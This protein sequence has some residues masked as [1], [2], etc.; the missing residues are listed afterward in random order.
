MNRL[1]VYDVNK[2]TI[3]LKNVLKTLMMIT[4]VVLGLS[5]LSCS[6]KKGV[7]KE[8]AARHV[9]SASTYFGQ[10]Q[11]HAAMLEARNAVQ[12]DPDNPAGF[13][14]LGRIYNVLG[15]FDAAQK[16]LEPIQ[17][18]M[19]DVTPDLAESYLNNGKYRSVINILS[20]YAP[21]A[22]QPEQ[23]I[24]R[25]TYLAQSYIRLGDK[26]GYEQS[27]VDLKNLPNADNDVLTIE[28]E[29]LISQGQ[30]EAAAAKL[31][32]LAKNNNLNAK[33]YLM[34]GNFALQNNERTKAEDFFT[35]ALGLLPN[36]DVMTLERRIV[37]TQLTEALILQGRTS[38]AYRYQKILADANPEGK[39]AQ[40]KYSDAMELYRQ[41]KFADAEKLLEELRD[42][43]PQ[44]KNSAMLLGLVQ[45]QRG[46]DEQAVELFDKYID[47]ETASSSL[48]QAAALAKFRVKKTDEAI[49]MLKKAVEAQ[50]NSA[51]ILATYGLALLD[52]DPVSDEGQKALEKSLA[53]SPE[54]HRLRLALAKRHYAMK[55]NEQGLA[56]LRTAYRAAP[57]DFVVQETYFKALMQ[58]G[59]NDEL[60]SEIANFQKENPGSGRG[61]FIEGWYKLVI[62]D[63]TGAQVAFEK[64]LA[65]KDNNE[66]VMAFTGLAELYQ[67]QNQPQKAIN[68]WQTLLKEDPTQIPVYA[69][70]YA[71][72]RE[73]KRGPEAI[74][75]LTELE[76]KTDKWQPSAVLAQLLQDQQR[77]S[78][79]VKYIEH[80]LERSG[81]AEN[82]KQLAANLY[83]A[84]GVQLQAQ[85]KLDDAK[86]SL[87]KSLNF[88]PENAQYLASL[89]Q[90]E[91]NQKNIPE[92]QKLLDQFV[93]T[94]ENEYIRLYLQ[95]VIRFA[96]EKKEE[97]LD[98]Y[99]KSWA[100]QPS[101]LVGE[102]LLNYYDKNQQKAEAAT[103]LSDWSK[104]LPKS[105]RAALLQAVN[106]Q[107]EKKADEAIKWYEKAIEIAPNSPI[108]LNNLAWMYYERKNPAAIE[109]A[110]KAAQLAPNSA[111]ILD[112]YGWIL[113]EN[114]Q[115][116]EGVEVLERANSLAK[117]NKEI[118]D[119][120]KAAKAK[121]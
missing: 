45:F 51:D 118:S 39:A 43:F 10:G 89:I 82:V 62:K 23:A 113:V 29:Y 96:E 85:G 49:A 114:G 61:A 79:A 64:A 55:N 76:S 74:T 65:V 54:K 109:L 93:H 9:T 50:P 36:T 57:I 20:S 35:K 37:L 102:A 101:E 4:V 110:K 71:I 90:F 83:H 17:K 100:S 3:E 108:A 2:K 27:L 44:D 21:E 48:I 92:A 69:K 120:L 81:K 99:R 94:D 91:I 1:H 8:G 60:K 16:T 28:S 75:F 86:V 12:K 11:F 106:A 14:M 24:R 70:W 7:D 46:Q 97:G 121:K 78:E 53:I 66:R 119:H 15:S 77:T 5:T 117:D 18:K 59:K 13:V 84:N 42:Q 30:K 40:Q 88:F 52:V 105:Y 112:T 115:I 34:L 98:L 107:N 58:A 95:G 111:E 22:N 38:E 41:G 31:D 72:A 25:L 47:T 116:A 32:L 19:P 73:L 87:L 104:K 33:T 67:I 63:Y 68:T 103:H 6:G 80:A 26:Q 56:Q